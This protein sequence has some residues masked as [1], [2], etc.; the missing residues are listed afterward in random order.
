MIREIMNKPKLLKKRSKYTEKDRVWKWYIAH[1]SV[2]TIKLFLTPF[3]HIDSGYIVAETLNQAKRRATKAC[4]R[5]FKRVG[6]YSYGN[7]PW[8]TLNKGIHEREQGDRQAL[9]KDQVKLVLCEVGPALEVDIHAL[10][11]GE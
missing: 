5:N 8:Y 10:T 6:N 2:Q 11:E 3:D 4:G 9:R 1:K 7:C